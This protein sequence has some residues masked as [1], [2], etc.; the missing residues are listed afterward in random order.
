MCTYT[1]LRSLNV[2]RSILLYRI[3]LYQFL[4]LCLI[5]LSY[6]NP[7]LLRNIIFCGKISMLDHFD[8]WLFRCLHNY[9]LFIK[10]TIYDCKIAIMYDNNTFCM[11]QYFSNHAQMESWKFACG[12]FWSNSDQSVNC[13]INCLIMLKQTIILSIFIF[14]QNQL[15]CSKWSDFYQ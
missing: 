4:Y 13:L 7:F 9:L 1:F 6:R 11:H 3:F 10:N 8:P 12:I 2:I 14:G 15:Y 5:S